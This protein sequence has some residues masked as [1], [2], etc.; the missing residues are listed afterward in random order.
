MFIIFYFKIFFLCD[1]FAFVRDRFFIHFLITVLVLCVFSTNAY[2]VH[3]DSFISVN[4]LVLYEDLVVGDSGIFNSSY[5]DVQDC[6]S[7]SNRGIINSDF[8]ID[9]AVDVYVQN[10]GTINGEFHVTSNSRLIQVVQ[11]ADDITYIDVDKN[12]NVFVHDADNVSWSDVFGIGLN[13]DKI[14]LDNSTLV[15]NGAPRPRLN[16][17]PREIEI[18][19]DVIFN[20]DSVDALDYSAPALCN[21]SGTGHV[22]FNIAGMNPIYKVVADVRDGDLYMKVVRNTDYAQIFENDIGNFLNVLRRNEPYDKLL[23][24]M[25]SAPDIETLNSIMADSVRLNPIKLMA[26]VRRMNNMDALGGWRYSDMTGVYADADVIFSDAS[27]MYRVNLTIT[28]SVA[29]NIYAAVGGYVGIFDVADN[30][31]DFSGRVY[32]ARLITRYDD[33]VIVGNLSGGVSRADFVA[34]YIFNDGVAVNN[35]G[36]VSGYAA[37]DIGAYLLRDYDLT[38]I[39][40]AGVITNYASVLNESDTTFVANC[41][42]D[43]SLSEHDFDILYDYGIRGNVL[44]DGTKYV[45]AFI[46]FFAPGDDMGGELSTSFINDGHDTGYKI[47]VS[48]HM[49]F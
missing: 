45:G 36:G 20:L 4:N 24:L 15:L 16:S 37:V 39:P 44:T 47:T 30:I 40:F 43:I 6:V 14:I 13:A 11:S 35:P 28:G 17:Q 5:T 23:I 3:V 38:I 33:G 22:L 41:G 27:S 9:G 25:D 8:Y 19:G 12:F 2:C 46:K 18:I 31:N 42:V 29:R 26:P 34:D 1:I 7:I 10:S 48:A 21:V 32:G 49:V